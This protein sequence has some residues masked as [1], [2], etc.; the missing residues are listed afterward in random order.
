[1]KLLSNSLQKTIVVLTTLLIASGFSYSQMNLDSLERILPKKQGKAKL[2]VLSDLCWEYGA[3]DIVKAEKYGLQA[4][5]LAEKVKD[6]SLHAQAMNDLGAVYLRIGDY[7]KSRKYLNGALEIRKRLKDDMGL[8]SVYSKLAVIEEIQ[9]NYTKSLD[10]NLKVL[11]IYE[12]QG[13]NFSAIAILYGNIAIIFANTKQFDLAKTYNA[14]GLKVAEKLK[15]EYMIAKCQV[16]FGNIY[17]QTKEYKRSNSYFR[18]SLPVL[19]KVNDLNS[20]GVVYHNI[21]LNYA[22]LKNLDSASYFYEKSLVIRTNL[23]D[24]NG[25]LSVMTSLAHIYNK[26]NKPQLAIKYANEALKES[27]ILKTKERSSNIYASLANSYAKIRD[28]EKAFL[29]LRRYTDIRDSIFTKDASQQILDLSTKYETE[30]KEKQILLL[31]KDKQV[32]VA[33]SQRQKGFLYTVVFVL[34]LTVLFAILMINR[35]VL[36]KKQK[37]HIE[38][39]KLLVEEKNKEITDSITYAKRIQS[40][41]LPPEKQFKRYLKDSFVFYQPKDIVAGDFYWFEIQDDIVFVAAADCTGHG[42]PGAMVSVVCHNALNRSLKEYKLTKPSDILDKTREIII[43]EFEKS[44]EDVKD[45]MDISLCALN[46]KTKTVQWA[47]AHNPLWILRNEE[48]LEFK[49]DKQPI[50]KFEFAKPFTNH[51][52]ELQENDEIYAVTDGFQD[53]F[54]GEKGKKF[55]ALQIKD[56]LVSYAGKSMADKSKQLNDVFTN[57]KGDLEQVDDVCIIGIKI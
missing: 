13:T 53:Q 43:A 51:E 35:F 55:K 52:I 56:L 38:L 45:G 42:V 15:D 16:N 48:I 2:K 5:K 29:N 46:L 57:W 37:K 47:G 8:A 1:M 54:G 34:I 44:D 24:R 20:L 21:G 39:Q 10:M 3:S 49:A 4:V 7:P 11:R 33:E 19:E 23:N 30:I 14:K 36:I 6:D 40:A 32:Q 26:L 22:D 27:E 50:G 17:S 18:K 12:K 28:F 31:K 25:R 9:S 41:I